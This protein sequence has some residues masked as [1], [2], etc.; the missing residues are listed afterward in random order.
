MLF[1]PSPFK[2]PPMARPL[3][4]EFP[5]AIYHVTSRGDRRESIFED[6]VDR[7]RFLAVLDQATARFDAQVLAY[8]LMGNHYHLVLHTRQGNLSLLMRHLNGVY[9]Q[10]YNRRH[11][12]VGHLLQGRF[13]AILVDRDAYLLTLCR[14]VELNPVRAK[15]GL[16]DVTKLLTAMREVRHLGK[17]VPASMRGKDGKPLV[18]SLFHKFGDTGTAISYGFDSERSILRVSKSRDLAASIS[19]DLSEELGL[20]YYLSMSLENFLRVGLR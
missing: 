13:K 17:E 12:V 1:A 3:R 8:C 15:L 14:Y 10:A 9:T 4:I 2:I 20:E 18:V 11:G 16:A 6:D 19:I 5:G 7:E